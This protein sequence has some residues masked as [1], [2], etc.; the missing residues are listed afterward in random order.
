M[1]S[2]PQGSAPP[3]ADPAEQPSRVHLKPATPTPG[4]Q[5][6]VDGAWWPRPRDLAAELPALFAAL[7][8]RLGTIERMAYNLGE[9]QPAPRRLATGT[10][11]VTPGGFRYQAANTVDVI[12]S[13]SRR[14]TL[15]VEP[16]ETS[17]ATAS[18]IALAAADAR[19]IERVD[20][21]LA[22]VAGRNGMPRPRPPL[23]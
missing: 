23:E 20:S 7:A 21:L 8:T 3:E 9:R 14:V 10:T 4:D 16:P 19:N 5:G 18:N 17:D 12:G 1:T 11:R 6:H 2:V 13:G 22:R 15:L